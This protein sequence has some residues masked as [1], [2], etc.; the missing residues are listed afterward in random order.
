MY[1]RALARHWLLHHKLSSIG[2]HFF[3]RYVSQNKQSTC[4]LSVAFIK[5]TNTLP[6]NITLEN[7]SEIQMPLVRRKPGSPVRQQS[8]KPQ[9]H[10]HVSPLS[11]RFTHSQPISQTGFPL[12]HHAICSNCHATCG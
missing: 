8:E 2:R 11:T 7:L 12:S 10:R 4:I 5:S 3:H 6:E 1:G 9:M